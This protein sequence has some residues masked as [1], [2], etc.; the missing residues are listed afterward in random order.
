MSSESA[1]HTLAT[2]FLSAF[3]TL[4]VSSHLALRAPT[5][6]HLFAPSTVGIPPKT[7]TEFASH[8]TNNL[9]ILSAFPV[10][11]KE[12]HINEPTRQITIWA[13]GKPQF[14]PEVM[15]GEISEWEYEGEYIFIL[16]VDGEGRIV[17]VLEFL[18]SLA[19]ERLRGLMGRAKRNVGE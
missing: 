4:S 13:T 8:I 3:T 9:S 16:D 2:T 6:T 14:K 17:R 1:L 18:D 10:S 7:N 5:C 15:D 11:A 12:I 19:T